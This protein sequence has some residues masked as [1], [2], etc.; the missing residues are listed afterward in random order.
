MLDNKNFYNIASSFYDQMISF[1]ANL[2]SRRD[3]F[4][5]LFSKPIVAADL[6]CG[7]GVDSIALSLNGHKVTGFDPSF[8]MLE[9]AKSNAL[10]Y[11]QSVDFVES[12]ILD[13]PALYNSQFELVL[14]L[15]NTFANIEG[16]TIY[17]TVQRLFDIL[18]PGGLCYIHILNYARITE[19]KERIVSIKENGKDF[20]VRFYDFVNGQVNFNILRFNKE[21]TANKE[22]LTTPIFAYK[23]DLLVKVFS[24]VGFI[25]IQ[26]FSNMNCKE[27]DLNKDTDLFLL[28]QKN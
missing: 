9:T 14:S 10:K 17:S 16:T 12:T 5:K 19:I 7:T 21:N 18:K 28:C 2:D 13:L 6:G 3:A 4:G 11:Q 15:G 27:F 24:S 23:R 20:Y 8:Q 1:E 26:Q 25:N 22:L